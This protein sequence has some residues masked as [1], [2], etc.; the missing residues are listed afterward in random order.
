MIKNVRGIIK[1]A[2]VGKIHFVGACT[3]EMYKE[4]KNDLLTQ[5]KRLKFIP[6]IE[7]DKNGD[8]SLGLRVSLKK[9]EK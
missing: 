1:N 4:I 5:R 7:V 9:K 8:W 6:L 2:V 3:D